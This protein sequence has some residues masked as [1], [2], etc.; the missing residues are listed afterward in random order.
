MLLLLPLALGCAAHNPPRGMLSYCELS[1]E[2]VSEARF[3]FAGKV[4]SVETVLDLIHR[5]LDSS[6]VRLNEQAV[7]YAGAP[8]VAT[9]DTYVVT[10][11]AIVTVDSVWKGQVRSTA[12]VALIDNQQGDVFLH[13]FPNGSAVLVFARYGHDGEYLA[14]VCSPSGPIEGASEWLQRLGTPRWR[15]PT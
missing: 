9:V 10:R 13:R 6:Q 11:T 3:I 8:V 2:A 15:A 1:D 4:A 12:R 7:M 5:N 14:S